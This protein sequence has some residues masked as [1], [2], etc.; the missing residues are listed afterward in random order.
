MIYQGMLA[1]AAMKTGRPVK[2]VYTREESIISTAKRHPARITYK[3]GLTRDGRITAVQFR[4]LSDGGAYGLSTE[5]VMRK[6]AILSCGPYDIPNVQIDTVGVYTNNT[7]SGAFRTFGAMQ[8]QFATETHLDICA[9]KLGLD[10]FEIR[11]I[12]M[13]RDGA[14]THTQQTLGSVS[15]G[16]VLEAAEKVSRWEPGAPGRGA[17]RTD[18][19]GEGTRKPC[20]LGARLGA[21]AMPATKQEVA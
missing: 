18:L 3:M 20:T 7:P 6:A 10:P 9:E 16:R 15:I 11:R 14:V 8:A 1:L 21:P 19:G 2:L 5:G 13:M 4:M 12:N 17:V